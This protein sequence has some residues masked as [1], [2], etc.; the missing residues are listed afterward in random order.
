M[1]KSWGILL[2]VILAGCTPA[3]KESGVDNVVELGGGVR[4]ETLGPFV[5]GGCP[6]WG[7]PDTGVCPSM[8]WERLAEIKKR[9][10]LKSG[11]AEYGVCVLPP[12]PDPKRNFYYAASILFDRVE[13]VPD[14]LFIKIVPRQ[15]FAVFTAEE[16]TT[17]KLI[18]LWGK[19]RR[20]LEASDYKRADSLVKIEKYSRA[21]TEKHEI[22]IPVV[23]K[24]PTAR[25]GR[26]DEEE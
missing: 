22:W 18:R 15:R 4:I 20:W 12:K 3:N 9:H 21:P 23:P 17:E 10:G 1:R 5:F 8:S 14:G 7:C 19:S 25:G 16:N 11:S 26:E 13:D 2:L 24:Q 6:Q